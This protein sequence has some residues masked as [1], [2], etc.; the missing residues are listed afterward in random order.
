MNYNN[1]NPATGAAPAVLDEILAV[2]SQ[3][4]TPWSAADL[5]DLYTED[6]CLFGGRPGH[7]IGRAAIT[8]Y[9]ASYDKIIRCASIKPLDQE[10]SRLNRETII[11]QGHV[12]FTF[13][14]AAGNDTKN[15]LRSTLI[16][17]KEEERWKIWHHHFSPVP[18]APPLG[19]G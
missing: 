8:G 12:E 1:A 4:A 9:F 18:E 6:A 14:L 17:R 7:S 19:E 5:G 3:A 10:V 16:L 2:W 15:L 13:L 11:A